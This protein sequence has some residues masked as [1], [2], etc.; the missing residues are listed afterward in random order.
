MTW[1]AK[2]SEAA[3]TAQASVRGRSGRPAA[4]PQFEAVIDLGAIAANTAVLRDCAGGAEVMVVV[5]ADGYGHGAVQVAQAALRAGAAQLGV[6]TVEEAVELR[7][8]GIDDPLLCWLH[9]PDADFAP[10]L[11]R[12][13]DVA[14]SSPRHLA[15]V[16]SA[17]EHTGVQARVAV[18][19]D[20]GLNRNGVSAFE[21]PELR[22][23][24]LR[25][26]AD[27][28]I[29]MTSFFSHLAHADEP[30]HPIIDR[31]AARFREIVADAQTHGLETGIL[32]LS[33]SA[34]TM[35]RSDLRFDMVRPGIALYGLSPVPERGQMGLRPAMTARTRVALVKKVAAGEGVS[36]GHVWIAPRD[37]TVALLPVGYA[38][39]IPRLLTGRF[40]VQINGRRYPAV[41]RVCMD[42]FVADLGPDGGSVREGDTAVLFG[43]GDTGEPIAQDW[44][45]TLGTIHY[46]VVTGIKGRVVRTYVGG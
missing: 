5:K 33:N 14:V 43:P 9:T 38:D 23:A 3:G 37:T 13:V 1:S 10:A 16:L 30:D 36:Y 15:G 17:A 7:D 20:S 42:Q 18:K 28:S 35:T 32:H 40:G 8:A 44:A 22:D 19:V 27:N 41:G 25:A 4:A 46:E 31:Q 12:G 2:A 45:D 24:L 6:A 39:G 29:V 26:V 11:V 34:A 21:W